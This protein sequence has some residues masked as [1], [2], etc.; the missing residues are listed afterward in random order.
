MFKPVPNLINILSNTA[1]TLSLTSIKGFPVETIY[2]EY[3]T[4]IT[5]SVVFSVLLSLFVYIKSFVPDALLAEGGDSGNVIYDFF[6]GRELNPRIG[7]FDIKEFCELRP[8][9]IGWMVINLGMA[10]KQMQATGSLSLSMI[11]INVFQGFYVWDALHS[12]KSI[13][14]TMDITTDGFGYMLAFGDLAW[15]PFIYSLQARYLV[16]YDPHMN[17]STIAAILMLQGFGYYVF[18]AANSEKDTFRRNPQDPRVNHL[19]YMETKRGTRLITSGWWG[20]ARKINYTGDWIMTFSWCLLCGWQSP[21]P[22]FQAV[23]FLILLIHRAIRDDKMCH[24][25]Y[26]DDWIEYKRRVPYVFIP[27]IV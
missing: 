6:I 26:G 17:I 15:V 9:L 20:M 13:L 11:L 3:L 21:I 8:G 7:S 5:A 4:L 18:R 19:T 16:D 24:E 14:S 25:K 22:Y 10:A 2:D 12:E 27:Y 23:Y 1:R